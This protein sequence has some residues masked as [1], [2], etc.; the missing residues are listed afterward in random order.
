MAAGQH[1]WYTV[2]W[3]G[4]VIAAILHG[5]EDQA[6]AYRGHRRHNGPVS[7]GRG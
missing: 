5:L 3:I 4:L 1:K 2:S 7:D 6:T